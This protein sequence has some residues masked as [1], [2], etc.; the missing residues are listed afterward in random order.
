MEEVSSKL[1]SLVMNVTA[2]EGGEPWIATT[3]RIEKQAVKPNLIDPKSWIYVGF[4][5]VVFG[6]P[7]KLGEPDLRDG[8]K[9][10]SEPDGPYF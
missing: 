9:P 5:E 10:Q 7:S 1:D 8:Y 4:R 2:D 3:D 6:G